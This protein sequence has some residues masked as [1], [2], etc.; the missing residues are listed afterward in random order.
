M[1]SNLG[2]VTEAVDTV[3]VEIKKDE[4]SSMSFLN[5][6][7][8]HIS[9]HEIDMTAAAQL[10]QD[11]NKLKD[12]H[13]ADNDGIFT[14]HPLLTKSVLAK[15]G[16]HINFLRHKDP[17]WT[18]FTA[19]G[20]PIEIDEE[21]RKQVRIAFLTDAHAQF[22]FNNALESLMSMAFDMST[23][24]GKSLNK[25]HHAAHALQYLW[26]LFFNRCQLA[27]SEILSDFQLISL[28]TV[29]TVSDLINMQSETSDYSILLN[30]LDGHDP[31][32]S[33][34]S[35]IVVMK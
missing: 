30:I 2:F 35:V 12:L 16:M 26:I 8:Q 4:I 15:Q 14:T 9:F 17:D 21:C 34:D 25:T 11:K 13:K 31:F 20:M 6:M 22:R 24:K 19:S 28:R 3:G 27:K 23:I 29:T 7:A 1:A 5:H 33:D 18:R 32:S 10:S